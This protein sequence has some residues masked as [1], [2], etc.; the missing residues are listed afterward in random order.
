VPSYATPAAPPPEFQIV[1]ETYSVRAPGSLPTSDLPMSLRLA[2]APQILGS[3]DPQTLVL[4]VYDP[5]GWQV[6]GGD[7]LT[8]RAS[9]SVTTTTRRFG[10]Y[11]LMSG[12]IWRDSFADLEGLDESASS[13]VT[14][15]LVNDELALVPEPGASGSAVSRLILSK[16]AAWG[17][18]TYSATVPIGAQFAVDLLSADGSVLLQD[19]ASGTNLTQIDA[20]THP[21]VRL[22]TRLT[23]GPDGERPGLFN[24]GISW[25]SAASREQV[26]LPLVQR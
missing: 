13:G 1:G 7:L 5:G 14:V 23:P 9:Y 3:I 25:T 22:R 12:S 8:E 6:L 24:W 15:G 20:Q 4:A 18:L 10:I 11:A 2:V 17:T 16:P 26:Y 19:V 21:S